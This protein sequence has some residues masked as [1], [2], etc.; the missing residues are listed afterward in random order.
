MKG[1]VAIDVLPH[2]ANMPSAS[3]NV[4]WV[5]GVGA[6]SPH[7]DIAYRFLK[8]CATAEIDKALTL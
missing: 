6:G 1:K 3:L 4:Y 7:A 8:H 5:L 2:A